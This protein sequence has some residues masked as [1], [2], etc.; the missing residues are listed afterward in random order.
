L[1]HLKQVKNKTRLI[2]QTGLNM[3][4]YHKTSLPRLRAS[5]KMMMCG[6]ILHYDVKLELKFML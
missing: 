1:N 3:L 2:A 6:I 4:W 5:I